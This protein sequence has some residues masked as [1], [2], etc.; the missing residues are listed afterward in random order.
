MFLSQNNR[1]YWISSERRKQ[2]VEAGDLL[3]AQPL[4]RIGQMS[5]IKIT[6]YGHKML[7]TFE[8]KPT[9]NDSVGREKEK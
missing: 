2:F 1:R 9:P 7:C 4:N 6:L 3:I 8:L 5:T